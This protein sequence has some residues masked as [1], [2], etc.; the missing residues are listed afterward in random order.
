MA[1]TIDT[2]IYS[3]PFILMGL[4]LI[5]ALIAIPMMFRV[6]VPT[7]DTDIV[8]RSKITTTY[9][10]GQ[11][12]G[13][14]YYHWP[15]WVPHYGVMVTKLPV[16]VFPVSLK[17]Y[18]A[19]DKGRVPFIIDIIGFFRIAEPSVA[20]ERLSS[21]EDLQRQL[22]GILQGAIRSILASNEIEEIL[23]GRSKFGDLFTHA[24]DDQLKQ[25]G[26]QTV[27]TIELMDIRDASDSKVISNIMAKKKSLIESQSRIEVALNVQR[28]RTAEIDANQ[29][30][31]IREQEAAQAVGLRQQ[32]ATQAV[33]VRTAQQEQNTEVAKEV[34]EQAVQDQA[35]LT[36]EKVMAV[37]QVNEVRGAEI[38]KQVQVVAAEQD[39]EV[40]IVKA[41]GTKQQTI[42]AAEGVLQS[43]RMQAEAIQVKGEAEGA[44]KYAMEIAPVNA[45]I[46]LA[47]EIGANKEYQYYLVTIKGIEKDQAVGIKQAEALTK[48][49]I[50][51]I[52]N[53]G[54]NVAD[55]AKSAM[56]LF[57]PAMGTRLGAAVEAF[58]QTPTG[59]AIL[60]KVTNGAGKH[61]A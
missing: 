43:Q 4:G 60:D 44:A 36:A 47:K 10:K 16:S 58:A 17:D 11:L 1:H 55:G 32:E 9:G 3:A 24:V 37:K 41:E 50:K 8:Q 18:A 23:E 34:A 7:N 20:A 5:I 52:A 48:A 30:V 59:G 54:S 40:N 31:G 26:V 51:V 61:T 6:V 2:I 13:N 39:K 28:A 14:T 46:A 35:K 56:D 49:D 19:Y 29:A 38:I 22:N 45:Q 12:A 33:N 42:L 53:T 21:F 27:K 25:W 15:S 57:S